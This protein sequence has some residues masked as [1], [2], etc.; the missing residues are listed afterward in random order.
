MLPMNGVSGDKNLKRF[1]YKVPGGKL[2]VAKVKT[3]DNHISFIQITGDFFLLPETDLEDLERKLVGI[4]ATPEIIKE[5]YEKGFCDVCEKETTCE[6][7]IC[8]ST[9]IASE[10][11]KDCGETSQK[12]CSYNLCKSTNLVC[13]NK[14]CVPCGSED[15][16]CC[17]VG[18]YKCV[19]G[20]T[21]SEGKCV[22][23]PKENCGSE[24][25]TCCEE[26]PACRKGL[27]CQA[28]SCWKEGCGFLDQEPCLTKTGINTCFANLIATETEGKTTCQPK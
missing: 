24:H 19:T 5:W 18:K 7:G 3:K 17:T 12:C 6:N 15:Q 14:V 28:N 2:L 10:E 1:E 9:M 21:C 23:E 26:A 16:D 25:Q 4:H 20:L 11:E 22:P 27:Q 13:K 8:R